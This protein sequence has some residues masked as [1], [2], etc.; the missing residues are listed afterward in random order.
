MQ[1]SAID[2]D[3]VGVEAED[4]LDGLTK[5]SRRTPGVDLGLDRDVAMLHQMDATCEA[6]G[7][8]DLGTAAAQLLHRHRREFVL[9]LQGERH[10]VL[11]S[12]KEY[13]G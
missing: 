3:E 6:K 8:G 5:S 13:K 11:A 9:H 1:T 7:G 2:D 12:G 10:V 4:L